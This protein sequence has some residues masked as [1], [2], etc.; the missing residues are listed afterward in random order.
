MKDD[1][2]KMCTYVFG[3]YGEPSADKSRYRLNVKRN[4]THIPLRETVIDTGYVEAGR[5]K[6]YMFQVPNGS[7][8]NIEKV[9]F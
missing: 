5:D 1:S 3:V 4:L 6:F 2:F 9:K 7:S 8:D